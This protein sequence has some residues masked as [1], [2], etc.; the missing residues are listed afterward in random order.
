MEK[1][2]Q[3]HLNRVQNRLAAGRAILRSLQDSGIKTYEVPNVTVDRSI[4]GINPPEEQDKYAGHH[5]S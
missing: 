3:D 2:I 1:T 4:L 5:C